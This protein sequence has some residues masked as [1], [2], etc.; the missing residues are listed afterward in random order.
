MFFSECSTDSIK[1]AAK[2]IAQGHLVAFPTETV[3]GLGADATNESA[4]AKIYKAKGRPADHPLIVHIASIDAM[5]D[6]A[7]D[8]S[9]YAINLA[10]DFWPGPMTL[11]FKRSQLAKDFV[12]GNQNTVG[13]RVPNQPIALALLKEFENLGGKGIAAPSANRFGAVSPTTAQAVKDELE[14]YLDQASDVILD[15]GPCQVGVE[16]TI[17]DCTSDTPQILRLGAITK[18]MIAES[19]GLLVIDEPTSD[20][21]VSGSLES[22][23]S[24]NAKVVLDAN[25]ETGDGFIAINSIPTPAGAIR[26]AA[27]SSIEGYAREI[28]SALRFADARGLTKVC[29]VQPEGDGL[30]AAIRDRLKRAAN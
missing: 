10:R 13:L 25:P 4:V 30:A 23:Y 15:G 29:V 17:I 16:S 18:E 5:G 12:T 27:P 11:I 26:L 22:H 6:W 1:A 28:Y 21:R 9:Q 2:S 8:I 14:N 20:I 19:T 7:E 3:Y 24:P